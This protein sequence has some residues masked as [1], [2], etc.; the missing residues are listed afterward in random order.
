[1]IPLVSVSVTCPHVCIIYMYELG[2]I[3]YTTQEKVK[4][5]IR[6]SLHILQISVRRRW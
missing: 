2:M 3:E 1:M 4:C 6:L 5:E